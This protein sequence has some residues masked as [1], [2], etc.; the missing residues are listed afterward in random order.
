MFV[1]C[2][3]S[4]YG[5]VRLPIHSL[6]LLLTRGF[7][8]FVCVSNITL[9]WTDI[10]YNIDWLIGISDHHQVNVDTDTHTFAPGTTAQKNLFIVCVF[11]S[12]FYHKSLYIYIKRPISVRQKAPF[13]KKTIN[14][15]LRIEAASYVKWRYFWISRNTEQTLLLKPTYLTPNTQSSTRLFSPK[16]SMASFTNRGDVAFI[17]AHESTINGK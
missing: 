11:V 7:R 17:K 8:I 14:H 9:E 16:T 3:S 15:K 10:K 6:S 2:I 1:F 12:L 4:G 13:T 5:S